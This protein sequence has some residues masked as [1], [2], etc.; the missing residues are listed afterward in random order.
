MCLYLLQGI[1]NYSHHN[2]QRC[3]TKEGTE[4]LC[5]TQPLRKPWQDT[6]NSKKECSRESDLIHNSTNIICRR[7]P[8]LNAGNKTIITFQVFAHLLRVEYQRRVQEG[9]TNNHHSI[10]HHVPG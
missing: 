2:K 1:K 8:G 7:L 9:K 6:Y 4:H 5:N 3:T 10:N